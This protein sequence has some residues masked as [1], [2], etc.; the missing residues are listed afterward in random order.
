MKPE[1]RQFIN[2]WIA[3]NYKLGE[4][5][6]KLF[7]AGPKFWDKKMKEYVK[8]R[9]LRTQDEYPIKETLLHRL[10]DEMHNDAF[11]AAF[12]ALNATNADYAT[13]KEM[14]SYRDSQLNQGNYGEAS[15]VADAIKEL[16]EIPR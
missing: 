4:R 1:E 5:V 6:E 8:E 7:N 12:Q 3:Q 11:M 15:R 9:G 10:L 14:A 13:R 16:T 2:N